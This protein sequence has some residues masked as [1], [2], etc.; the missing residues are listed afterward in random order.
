MRCHQQA[1]PR[2]AAGCVF[3]EEGRRRAR[4][5]RAKSNPAGLRA[6]FSGTA[7]PDAARQNPPAAI[8]G[9]P[10]EQGAATA[11]LGLVAPCPPHARGPW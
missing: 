3:R 7:W 8:R 11:A 9:P 5:S 1:L 4:I 10:G 2:A 6:G